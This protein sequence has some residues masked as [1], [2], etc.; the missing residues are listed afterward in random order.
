M[1]SYWSSIKPA[2]TCATASIT[3]SR[4]PSWRPGA[5]FELHLDGP[6]ELTR[7]LLL[8]AGGHRFQR[9]PPTERRGR[10]QT[11][12]ITVS[13]F[14]LFP[15]QQYKLLDR[16]IKIFATTA[17][18]PGGQHQRPSPQS[19]CG[20]S[21]PALR[22]VHQ[23]D[24]SIKTNASLGLFWRLVLPISASGNIRTTKMKPGRFKSA[25]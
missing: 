3:T 7:P 11:S 9:I 14:E 23:N 2:F 8:E 19:L 20:T 4:L 5:V 24:V 15:E 6:E 22:L 1:Q 13:A 12:T 21:R 17:G 18:G 25:R 16:D 10:V